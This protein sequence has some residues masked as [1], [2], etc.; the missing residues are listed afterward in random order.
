MS[1]DDWLGLAPEHGDRR[2][3]LFGG[4]GA[5]RVWELL[6]DAPTGPFVAALA[7]ALDV[8]G[9]VGAH[10]QA[11]EDEIVVCLEGL[12]AV[13]VAGVASAFAPGVA[14]YVPVGTTLSLRN[15]G[16]APLRYLIVKATP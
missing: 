8:G 5:V 3:A 9:S 4:S 1:A 6:P 12:G 11:R 16:D 2:E 15:E 7:C 10:V 13:T 14:V